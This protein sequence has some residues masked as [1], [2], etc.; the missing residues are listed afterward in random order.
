M[1]AYSFGNN[2]EKLDDHA[3]FIGNFGLN[4]MTVGTKRP[5]GWGLYDMHGLVWEWCADWFGAYA[6]NQNEV[7]TN[8]TGP[9]SG[10][11]RVCRGGNWMRE[12]RFCRSAHRFR[13]WPEYPDAITGFRVALDLVPKA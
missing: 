13:S 4:P 6:T 7:V 1:T 11:L 3:W 2:P 9:K 8:P 10:R 5:N 12:A